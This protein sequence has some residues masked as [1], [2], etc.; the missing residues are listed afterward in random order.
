VNDIVTKLY[1]QPT[2][3][4][5]VIQQ[6][7]QDLRST[8]D[9]TGHR[10]AD[11][12][13]NTLAAAQPIAGG[14]AGEAAAA[15]QAGDT[16]WGRI[17]DLNRLDAGGDTP[18][19]AAVKQTMAFQQPDSPQ[20]QSLQDLQS[21]MKPSFN[22]W[23]LRHPAAALLGAGVGVAE[24]QLSPD[25]HHNANP[26]GNAFLHAGAGAA[27]FSGLPAI[28]AAR[29]GAALN[30]ARYAIGTGQPMTTPTGRVGDALLNLILARGASNQT[31]Y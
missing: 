10:F 15:Q 30:A 29:P 26:W 19:P 20:Y 1:R 25:Q 24:D 21:A 2:A 23:H 18:T 3:T 9:W 22:W 7:S 11:A 14:Q 16:L 6:A 17:K 12:L 8:G 31:P 27:L 4:G 28:A 5:R 13:D